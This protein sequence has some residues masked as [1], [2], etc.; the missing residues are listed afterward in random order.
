MQE[1]AYCRHGVDAL[2]TGLRDRYAELRV[3]VQGMGAAHEALVTRLEQRLESLG[4]RAVQE[5]LA[6]LTRQM[7]DVRVAAFNQMNDIQVSEL[8]YS[9]DPSNYRPNTTAKQHEKKL[10]T[11]QLERLVNIHRRAATAVQVSLSAILQG[12]CAT[13][14]LV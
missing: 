6:A 8:S 3:R 9:A 14:P 12:Q 7:R 4:V 5:K 1:V 11:L 10:M 2:H 13:H